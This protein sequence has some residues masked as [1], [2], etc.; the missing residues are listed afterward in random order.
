MEVLSG[1]LWYAGLV[2]ALVFMLVAYHYKR[3]LARFGSD[4]VSAFTRLLG[5]DFGVTACGVVVLGVVLGSQLSTPPVGRRAQ[6][7]R[8]AAEL[9]AYRALGEVLGRDLAE[10]A[11]PGSK[12]LVI[13]AAGDE[14]SVAYAQAMLAGLQASFGSR[15]ALGKHEELR[16]E[17]NPNNPEQPL[18]TALVLETRRLNNLVAA[19]SDC[20]VVVCLLDVAAEF[21]DTPVA[22]RAGNGTALVGVFSRNPYQLG[23]AIAAG[24]ITACVVPRREY[25]WRPPA[26]TD[27]TPALFSQRFVLVTHQ[28]I[29]DVAKANK[30]LFFLQKRLE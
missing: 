3:A 14:R 27:G 2:F 19:N 16:P 1:L 15:I 17:D 28:N 22:A 11:N 10:K 24:K 23:A 4:E 20:N 8:A 6:Q 13:S 7:A 25:R 12:A 30:T 26:P 18:A 29:M 9:R 21:E 5:T